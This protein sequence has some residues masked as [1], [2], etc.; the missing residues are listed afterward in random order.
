[1]HIGQ[2]SCPRERPAHRRSSTTSRSWPWEKG[3]DLL[4]TCPDAGAGPL[5]KWRQWPA[6]QVE[7]KRIRTAKGPTGQALER[8]PPRAQTSHRLHGQGELSLT[9][10]APSH[11]VLPASSLPRS[12]HPCRFYVGSLGTS[13][14]K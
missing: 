10:S 12:P 4:N 5:G 11:F 9:V 8:S 6:R 7:A 13:S 3:S 1:M 14:E 2:S